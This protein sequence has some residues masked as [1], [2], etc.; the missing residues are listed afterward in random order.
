MK[1]TKFILLYWVI[2]IPAQIIFTGCNTF[3]YSSTEKEITVK[4]PVWPP[5]DQFSDFYPELS[6]WKITIASSEKTAVFYTDTDNLTFTVEK[7]QPFCILAQPLTFLD[8]TIY[9]QNSESNYFCPAGFL[10]PYMENSQNN[11]ANQLTWEQ[12]FLAS[13]MIKIISAKNETGISDEHTKSFLS[14]FNWKKAQ[15]TIENKIATSQQTNENEQKKEAVYNPWLLDCY[16]LLD[17][18][19][20]GNFKSS[21]LNITGTFT[22]ELKKL[23][24]SEELL[25]L[26][27]FIPENKTLSQN[28]QILLKKNCDNFLSNGKNLGAVINCY[29]AKKVSLV[30]IYM[31]IFN[32]DI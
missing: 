12:G 15:E 18:L 24:S 22:Y 14:S 7:N 6:R 16:K 27:P 2:L 26:S 17:N 9:P 3:F 21:Y 11:T 20:Y 5:N 25:V 8:Q 32:E 1:N 10:Y 19:C 4:L 31:P 23:F 29:S 13:Q 28:P 30:Y